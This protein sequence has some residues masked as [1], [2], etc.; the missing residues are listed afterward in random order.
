MVIWAGGVV[1]VVEYLR[2]QVQGPEFK[3][4]Y[5]QNKT[6]KTPKLWII[7]FLKTDS[8]A[9]SIQKGSYCV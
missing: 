4:Q 3:P 7:C 6:P 8:S 2:S 5:C 1:Q 9:N